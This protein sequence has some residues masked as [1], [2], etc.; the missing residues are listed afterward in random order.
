[1]AAK[2]KAI[3]RYGTTK[4]AMELL[5]VSKGTLGRYRRVLFQDRHYFKPSPTDIR[6]YLEPLD[7]WY[8][9]GKIISSD[10]LEW[11]TKYWS[12]HE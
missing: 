4:E 10:H 1:V 11:L 9:G 5:G 2:R 12:E 8:R 7:H 3:P 6:W